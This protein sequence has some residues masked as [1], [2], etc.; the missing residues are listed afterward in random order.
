MGSDRSAPLLFGCPTC[1]SMSGWHSVHSQR[2]ICASCATGNCAVTKF[3][4]RGCG[5]SV[6][7]TRCLYAGTFAMNADAQCIRVCGCLVKSCVAI[8][9]V[10]KGKC[11]P[12]MPK[13]KKQALAS[14]GTKQEPKSASG[15]QEKSL[16]IER[17]KRLDTFD[18]LRS[19][20]LRLKCA[21]RQ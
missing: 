8:G 6:R 13:P 1:G 12:S 3:S 4:P 18:T 17:R 11:W 20:Q 21:S 9:A 5:A 14:S 10:Q 7:A 16:T 19:M 2:S 15:S